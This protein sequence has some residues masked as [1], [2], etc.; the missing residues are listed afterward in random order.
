MVSFVQVSPSKPC[1]LSHLSPSRIRR[2]AIPAN[3]VR[4]DNPNSSGDGYNQFSPP[5]RYLEPTASALYE[6][7]LATCGQDILEQ[8][9]GH[10]CG[11]VISSHGPILHQINADK[12][13]TL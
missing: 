4:F 10:D 8:A 9:T 5:V 6:Q 2:L 12:K 11:H 7:S 3:Y 1:I 13:R